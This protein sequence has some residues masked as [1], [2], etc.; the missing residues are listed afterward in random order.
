[1]PSGGLRQLSGTPCAAGCEGVR[2]I[3]LPLVVVQRRIREEN[4]H[5]RLDR[6][7]CNGTAGIPTLRAAFNSALEGPQLCITHTGKT[8][9]A[10]VALDA[11]ATNG[12]VAKHDQR[13]L[14]VPGGRLAEKDPVLQENL[15]EPCVKHRASQIAVVIRSSR[16]DFATASHWNLDYNAQKQSRSGWRKDVAPLITMNRHGTQSFMS[17]LFW[18]FGQ[19]LTHER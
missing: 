11:E 1:M 6:T 19:D 9:R 18:T 2:R 12:E 10:H 4:R 17:F 7:S 14:G 5:P 8:H 16:H 13:S 15:R 3:Y